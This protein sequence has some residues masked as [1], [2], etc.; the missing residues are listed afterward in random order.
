VSSSKG[1]RLRNLQ[2]RLPVAAIQVRCAATHG[3][4]GSGTCGIEVALLGLC[5]VFVMA[6]LCHINSHFRVRWQKNAKPGYFCATTKPH[7]SHINAEFRPVWAHLSHFDP[8]PGV[9]LFLYRGAD[10][11]VFMAAGALKTSRVFYVLVDFGGT[12]RTSRGLPS[13]RF[14]PPSKGAGLTRYLWR[15]IPRQQCFIVCHRLRMR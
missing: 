15:A 3:V 7:Q 14:D 8:V 4:L 11:K 1:S 9:G 12:P 5:C 2:L 13:V 6:L 10:A